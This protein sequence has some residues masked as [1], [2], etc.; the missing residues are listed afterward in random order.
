MTYEQLQKMKM[1]QAV[2]SFLDLTSPTIKSKLQNFDKNLTDFK[3]INLK[4]L[5]ALKTQQRI[6]TGFTANKKEVREKLID[7]ALDISSR[8]K[9]H[10]DQ[11]NNIV[12][13]HQNKLSK[14]KLVL[15]SAQ[16]CLAIC[17]GLYNRTIKILPQLKN[18]GM[19][20]EIMSEYSILLAKF[21]LAMPI[22]RSETNKTKAA[23]ISIEINKAARI[24]RQPLV[25][26]RQYP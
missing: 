24:L 2:E 17:Q 23:T 11:S 16:S 10:A 9:A 7:M 1:N 8:V 14:R 13:F 12:L 15:S 22:P 26:N 5:G 20:E 6:S 21:S 3:L 25:N 18:F 19:T 4:T